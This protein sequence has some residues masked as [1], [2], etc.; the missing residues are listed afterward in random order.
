MSQY[1]EFIA[2]HPILSGSAIALIVIIVVYE[3]RRATRG[4]ADLEPTDVTRL[5]NNEDAV[6]LDVRT[7]EDFEKRHILNARSVPSAELADRIEKLTKQTAD[8]PVIVYC[9]TGISSGRAASL[10]VQAG[11]QRVYSLKGGLSAWET[12]G[13]PV[14]KKRK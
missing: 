10:L 9:D 11:L 6:L 5:M 8:K 7:A 1:L 2:N 3:F 14:V 12:A 4:F 13:L